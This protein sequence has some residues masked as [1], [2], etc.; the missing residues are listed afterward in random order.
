MFLLLLLL[1]LGSSRAGCGGLFRDDGTLLPRLSE[2]SNPVTKVDPELLPPEED[3]LLE[4][5]DEEEVEPL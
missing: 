3:E 4:D 2:E 1:L 5:D